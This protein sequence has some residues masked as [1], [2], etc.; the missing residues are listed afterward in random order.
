M[1]RLYIF[2]AL[3]LLLS[4]SAAS[5][6]SALPL[7]LEK[8]IL[9]PAVRGRIDHMSIDTKNKRLFVAALGNNTLE[10]IDLRAGK[11][12]NSIP[13]L[14]EPQGVLYVPALD[15]LYVANAK[16]GTVQI[17][18]GSSFKL[19]KN[20]SYDD[21]AD[22]IRFD[23]VSGKVY[24][25]YGSGAL[26]AI[27]KEGGKTA[28]IKLDAHPESFQLEKNGPRIFVNLPHS[29]KI[30]VV[31]RKT[32]AVIA[33]WITGGPQANYP[34]AFDEANHRLF[35]VCR[36]PARLIVLDTNTGKIVQSL[37]TSGDCDDV[38]YD[39]ARTRVYAVGGEG[40]I[41]VFQQESLNH[42]KELASIKTVKGAR[43]GFFSPELGR[44]YVAARRQGAK[45][46]AIRVY[47]VQP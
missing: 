21:D 38:F 13:G 11:L 45:P 47:E 36:S 27:D 43:T 12:A 42:Y 20:V 37:P 24:I 44:L 19:L 31:D 18:D 25:G 16:D 17:F 23:S 33:T 7:R 5:A 35:V 46:A 41:S 29:Q 9:M 32:G 22:N 28:D 4:C 1:T 3:W 26:G 10:V 14:N 39:Q 15:R 2:I 34:M 6:Q 8:T 40:V 30:A